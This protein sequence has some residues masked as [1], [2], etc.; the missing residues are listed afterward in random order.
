[1]D[2]IFFE[3]FGMLGRMAHDIGHVHNAGMYLYDLSSSQYCPLQ[4][5]ADQF[6]PR[7]I[8][9]MIPSFMFPALDDGASPYEPWI[10]DWPEF[11]GHSQGT[12]L[13]SGHVT[14]LPQPGNGLIYTCPH[15]YIPP[16]ASLVLL[17]EM[18]A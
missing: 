18:L 14:T 7:N 1:M 3:V 15:I 4:R 11:N 6:Q 13:I 10:I 12:F 16:P 17:G 2:E 9:Y 5:Q 8:L